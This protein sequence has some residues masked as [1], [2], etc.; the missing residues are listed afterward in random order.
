MASTAAILAMLFETV[1]S[2]AR[3]RAASIANNAGMADDQAPEQ[4]SRFKV[5]PEVVAKEAEA[6]KRLF[7][8]RSNGRSQEAFG[9]EL[10]IGTQGM[11]WQY[12]N[13]RRP[14]NVTAAAAFARGLG[15]AVS[16]FSKRLA[17]EL[18]LL[19][20]AVAETNTEYVPDA[21]QRFP[22]I[23]WVKAGL[24][25]E[26]FDPYA[27]GAAEAWIDYEGPHVSSI[28]FYLRVRGRSMESPDGR[29]PTFPDGCLILVDPRRRPLSGECCV[30]RF[31]SR[32]EVTFKQYTRRGDLQELKPLN[33]D[34]E[35]KNYVIG[36]DARLV[37]TVTE[38]KIIT[39]Y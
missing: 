22:L 39:R 32:N 37:G 36:D 14:L 13:G 33:P 20:R 26:A 16:D 3:G 24:S 11:V 28:S 7:D 31:D 23:S 5:L 34:P 29:E 18:T 8:E 9:L 38:K 12:L 4:P 21:R 25:E 19:S 17:V 2:G 35:Y 6:L 27:P 1:K 30:W 10:G 15:V